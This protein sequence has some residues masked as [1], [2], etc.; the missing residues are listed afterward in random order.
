MEKNRLE[1]FSDGVLAI[2]ITIMV[3]ELKVPHGT[4]WTDLLALWPVFISYVLSFL[5]I[6]IYWGNH[7]HLMHTARRVN[8]GILLTNLHL[9]FWLSLIPFTTAWMGE[10]HFESNPVAL[11]AVNLTAAGIAY[12][13]LQKSI[14]RHH[15]KDDQLK[16]AFQRHAKKGIVSQIAYAAAIPL[17]YVHPMISG[18]IFLL[19]AILWIVPAKEIEEAIK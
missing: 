16:S 19:I 14:E 4:N 13:I 1:A 15:A 11:Y 3:L 7:H 6:G 9:L 17:A 5:Y 12:F 10:N 18:I 2:I 8:S